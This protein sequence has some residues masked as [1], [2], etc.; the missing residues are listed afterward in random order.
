MASR[1]TTSTSVTNSL[2]TCFARLT[3]QVARGLQFDAKGLS[4]LEAQHW[5]ELV[6][7]GL[8]KSL[9]RSVPPGSIVTQAAPSLSA[10][11]SLD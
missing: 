2:S 11:Q 6:I 5:A 10:V 8:A 1:T 9:A 4:A 7:Q 3:D